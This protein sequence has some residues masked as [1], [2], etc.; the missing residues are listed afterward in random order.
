MA[1]TLTVAVTGASGFL[2]RFVCRALVELG[3]E[4]VGIGHI[5]SRRQ[6]PEDLRQHI[7]IQNCDVVDRVSVA[8]ALAG[9]DAV[10]H[11]AAVVAIDNHDQEQTRLVNAVGTRNVLH[12]CIDLGISRIVHIGSV[13]AYGSMRGLQLNCDSHLANNSR[14]AYCATKAQA[15]EHVLREMSEGHIGGC[16]ICPSGIIGPGDEQPTVVGTMLL[17][18]ACKRLPMLINAGYW[19]CDVRDVAA[20]VAEAVA[21]GANGRVYFTS[22]QYAN[23]GRLAEMC[24]AALSRDVTCPAVP[25]WV[26]AAA[27]PLVNAYASM[28]G[29]APLYTR[30]SLDLIRNCPDTIDDSGAK[31]EIGYCARPLEETV[32]DTL[33]WFGDKGMLNCT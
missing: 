25:Y 6:W 10:V 1:N 15:H 17:E 3:Y 26:A 9:A 24:S 31:N 33:A 29:L 19:W 12:S 27:R 21:R 4:T 18:I 7:K 8:A 30:E 14:L 22:G 2:G 13:H 32:Q 28:R 16:M 11:C 23:L 20:S 5:G